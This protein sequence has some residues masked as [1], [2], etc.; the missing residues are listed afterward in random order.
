[1]RPQKFYL[2]RTDTYVRLPNKVYTL[3]QL[4]K[5]A[6]RWLQGRVQGIWTITTQKPK[7]A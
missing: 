7:N 2:A 6:Q 5:F 1:M 4:K 3:G